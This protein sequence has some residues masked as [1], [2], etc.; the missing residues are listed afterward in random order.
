MPCLAARVATI[1]PPAR[2]AYSFD[3]R[4]LQCRRFASAMCPS[5][6]LTDRCIRS[7]NRATR[8]WKPRPSLVIP[9]ALRTRACR[10]PS[11]AK[12]AIRRELLRRPAFA[13]L[14]RR[15]RTPAE[16]G[17]HVA[18]MKPGATSRAGSRPADLSTTIARSQLLEISLVRETD[19]LCERLHLAVVRRP[20]LSPR[21]ARLA[22][23]ACESSSKLDIH[24]A[25]LRRVRGRGRSSDEK[26]GH[27]ARAMTSANFGLL[28]CIRKACR[29][30]HSLA[31]RQPREPHAPL[32][33]SVAIPLR[34][35]A[36][37]CVPRMQFDRKLI[38]RSAP[39]RARHR[40]H[41]GAQS[42]C[43]SSALQRGRADG[44]PGADRL[45]RHTCS[46]SCSC[47]GH[48]CSSSRRR[49]F[50][51]VQGTILSM[52]GPRRRT[53]A[54]LIGGTS[55]AAVARRSLDPAPPLSPRDRRG[56]M[57]LLFLLRLSSVQFC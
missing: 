52:S 35:F 19:L 21:T 12:S 20:M 41:C 49:V 30:P 9:V 43:R 26:Q 39:S 33:G 4:E 28:P 47:C 13:Q 40:R 29:P 11:F 48:S 45:V 17:M 24:D 27:Q 18:S 3:L 53:L 57:K 34:V 6:G 5:S 7:P 23:G 2:P 14:H 54:F 1:V 32:P 16:F 46:R 42:S 10:S 51:L 50:G 22:H 38:S 25:R 44:R 56:R 55:R 36:S 8:R 37:R 15:Q 31:S